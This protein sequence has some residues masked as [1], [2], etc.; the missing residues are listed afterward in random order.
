MLEDKSCPALTKGTDLYTKDIDYIA[1]KSNTTH[2]YSPRD[3]LNLI[4]TNRKIEFS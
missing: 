2:Q 4:Y 3:K 1:L